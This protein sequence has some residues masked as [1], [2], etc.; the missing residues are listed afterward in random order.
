[1]PLTFMEAMIVIAIVGS[2]CAWITHNNPDIE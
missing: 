1:M 2:F